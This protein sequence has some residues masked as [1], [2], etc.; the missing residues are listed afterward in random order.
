MVYESLNIS[1]QNKT[2]TKQNKTK[3][4]EVRIHF[5]LTKIFLIYN[6]SICFFLI[7]LFIHYTSLDESPSPPST[8]SHRSSYHS[9]L[10]SPLP[11]PFH[12]PHPTHPGTSSQYITWLILVGTVIRPGNPVR[13]MGSTD[14]Q[15]TDSVI[16]VTSIV[17]GPT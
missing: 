13:E 7:Y 8:L 1:K 17:G 6:K 11:Q 16:T 3:T 12:S 10:P 14:R 2:K 4:K 5:F 15:A 9:T